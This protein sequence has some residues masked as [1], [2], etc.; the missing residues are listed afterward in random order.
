MFV[1]FDIAMISNALPEC[2]VAVLI[3]VNDVVFGCRGP[4]SVASVSGCLVVFVY[5]VFDM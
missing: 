4:F 3:N 5:D 2:V 1:I